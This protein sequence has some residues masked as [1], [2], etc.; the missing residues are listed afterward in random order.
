MPADKHCEWVSDGMGFQKKIEKFAIGVE[1]VVI[2][3]AWVGE[4]LGDWSGFGSNTTCESCLPN[5]YTKK[6][7]D[8]MD[9]RFVVWTLVGVDMYSS[10]NYESETIVF[11]EHTESWR[12]C[13]TDDDLLA[14]LTLLR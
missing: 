8:K 5:L 9:I 7:I 3:T 11:T 1:M 2:V 14:V 13:T 6:E 12:V 10:E 4:G